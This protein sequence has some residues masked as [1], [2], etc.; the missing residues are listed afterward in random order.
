M[1]GCPFMLSLL[2]QITEYIICAL[3]NGCLL[4]Y[5]AHEVRTMFSDLL[6]DFLSLFEQFD[7]RSFNKKA[8]FSSNEYVEIS[9]KIKD[10]L[11]QYCEDAVP[12]FSAFLETLENDGE[13]QYSDIE[14]YVEELRTKLDKLAYQKAYTVYQDGSSGSEYRR[15]GVEWASCSAPTVIGDS[16]ISIHQRPHKQSDEES[17][18]TPE[19]IIEELALPVRIFNCLKRAGINTIGDL[20][21]KTEDELRWVRNL[22]LHGLEALIDQLASLGLSLRSEDSVEET[23]L[24][25]KLTLDSP[26]DELDLSL[27]VL[28]GLKWEGIKTIREIEEVFKGK[29]YCRRIS[30]SGFREIVRKLNE[31]DFYFAQI[32]V[33]C[34]CTFHNESHDKNNSFCKDCYEKMMRVQN[35]KDISLEILPPIK[36]SYMGNENG[37]HLFINIRNTT[38]SPIKLALKECCIFKGARQH[39]SNYN[40]TGYVFSE[41]YIFPSAV[42][43]FAKIWITDTWWNSDIDYNDYLT[44]SFQNVATGEIYYYKFTFSKK[45]NRWTMDDYYK[46][47]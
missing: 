14:Q 1:T 23:D 31:N 27:R 20:T 16:P 18:L 5:N 6:G 3:E 38:G 36:S 33:K 45:D 4:W 8:L 7:N 46:I 22:G 11:A 24:P 2:E 15:V 37:F 43:T 9:S 13:L 19:T 28:N 30:A 17:S 34:N 35:S 29:I 12:E 47:D 41:D 21:A 39:S 26:V 40:L 25:K 44:I 32:C 10:Y 42:K